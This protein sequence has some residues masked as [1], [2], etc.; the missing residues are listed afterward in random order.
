[1]LWSARG[2]STRYLEPR[3][4]SREPYKEPR[5]SPS[6]PVRVNETTRNYAPAQGWVR[7]IPHTS[8]LWIAHNTYVRAFAPQEGVSGGDE[9]ASP[10]YVLAAQRCSPPA[11]EGSERANVLALHVGIFQY[12][13]VLVPTVRRVARMRRH[14]TSI[15]I[16]Y[17]YESS[18]TSTRNLQ[19]VRLAACNLDGW[20]LLRILH[21]LE[22]YNTK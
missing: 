4:R 16:T 20:T 19:K 2:N 5:R 7:E 10:Y 13:S 17:R 21:V 9:S 22:A 3:E 8:S 6:R 12:N 15:R 18:M 11:S 1:M 14:L